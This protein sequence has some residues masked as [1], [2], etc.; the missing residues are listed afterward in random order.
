MPGLAAGFADGAPNKEG[1]Q[2]EFG[3]VSDFAADEDGVV[4]VPSAHA[5]EILKKAQEL[6]HT[7]HSMYPFI[8]R[9]KSLT[10]AIARFGRI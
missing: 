8:E 9:F 6:D 10:E 3:H 5:A 4:V 7:E 2:A 1:E